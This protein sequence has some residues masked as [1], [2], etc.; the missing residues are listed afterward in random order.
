M[1]FVAEENE[2]EK[3][4][5]EVEILLKKRESAELK[6]LVKWLNYNNYWNVWFSLWA[7]ENAIKLIKKFEE[8]LKVNLNL[9]KKKTS[10]QQK[11][12]R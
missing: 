2:D 7:L 4:L 11:T 10:Y 3:N 9:I 8:R 12:F 5:F 6:Y 1:S